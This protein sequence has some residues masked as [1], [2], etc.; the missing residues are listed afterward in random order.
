MTLEEL[1]KDL[2]EKANSVISKK[3]QYQKGSYPDH[4]GVHTDTNWDQD[5]ICNFN[6]SEAKHVAACSPVVVLA[7]L[8][9]LETYS[10]TLGKIDSDHLDVYLGLLLEKETEILA[11]LK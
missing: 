1:V 4:A 5:H 6:Y 2:R 11:R 10:Y 7:L 9:L 8:E 3:W